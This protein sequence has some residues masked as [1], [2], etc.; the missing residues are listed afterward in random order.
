MAAIST[1]MKPK[2]IPAK[3]CLG[4][5]VRFDGSRVERELGVRCQ[6]WEQT[7]LETVASMRGL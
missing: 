3:L 6:P 1:R 2:P 4:R 5:E 7:V